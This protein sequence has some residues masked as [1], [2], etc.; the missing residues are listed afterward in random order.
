MSDVNSAP[1][2]LAF[3]P[4]TT[5]T[6]TDHDYK[7]KT[8]SSSV[9][10]YCIFSMRHRIRRGKKKFSL[11]FYLSMNEVL[12]TNAEYVIASNMRNIARLPIEYCTSEKN[13]TQQNYAKEHGASEKIIFSQK[14]LICFDRENPIIGN[15]P[16]HKKFCL[17]ACVLYD[18]ERVCVCVYVEWC[19]GG[20]KVHRV[21]EEFSFDWIPFYVVNFR[22]F[23]RNL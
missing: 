7:Q 21:N 19:V 22:L 9:K 18:C 6:T 12:W 3:F 16:N 20:R 8:T 10:L 11:L 17:V 2:A 14:L 4:A 1:L 13:E 5:T 23:S 15:C